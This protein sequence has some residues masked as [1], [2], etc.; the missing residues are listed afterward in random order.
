MNSLKKPDTMVTDALNVIEHTKAKFML[1]MAH[2]N[3]VRFQQHST[4]KIIDDLEKQ[5]RTKNVSVAHIIIDFKMK[6]EP[7]SS[8]ESTQEHFGKRGIGWHGVLII[9]FKMENGVPKRHNI[10][11]DQIMMDGTKQDAISVI[12]LLDAALATIHTEMKEIKSISLQ[13]DNANC[14]QGSMVLF[15]VLF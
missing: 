8:R 6:Y 11:I 1:Y 14:Y 5:C 7:Q 13:S 9:I 15:G 10:Y 12:G 4:Q 2:M 3:R